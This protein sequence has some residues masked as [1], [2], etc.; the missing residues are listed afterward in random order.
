MINLQ[1]HTGVGNTK[2][3]G[4]GWQHRRTA[5]IVTGANGFARLSTVEKYLGFAGQ[6]GHAGSTSSRPQ[7]LVSVNVKII[8]LPPVSQL[9]RCGEFPYPIQIPPLSP[10]LASPPS[11]WRRACQHI[12]KIIPKIKMH[13]LTGLKIAVGDPTT[14]LAVDVETA[15]SEELKSASRTDEMNPEMKLRPT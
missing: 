10:R 15:K 5:C 11:K 2:N 6:L 1:E 3:Q 14:S 7:D 8:K 4:Q 9:P 12:P 13:S